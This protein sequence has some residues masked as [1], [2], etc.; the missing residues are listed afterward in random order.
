M[1]KSRSGLRSTFARLAKDDPR[2][3]RTY[4]RSLAKAYK[5]KEIADY[6]ASVRKRS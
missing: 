1:V 6:V 5:F 4:T 2:V 3:D